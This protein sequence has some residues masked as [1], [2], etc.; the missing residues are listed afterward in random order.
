MRRSKENEKGEA[1]ARRW[2]RWV[3]VAAAA[4][5]TGGFPSVAVCLAS[6]EDEGG[7]SSSRRLVTVT[8]SEGE[9]KGRTT[10]ENHAVSW[11]HVSV[12]YLLPFLLYN[13]TKTD[14]SERK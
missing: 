6:R 9:L 10:R 12:A 14:Y 5:V 2:Y 1:A 8:S 13:L 11:P 3:V 4:A 7:Q